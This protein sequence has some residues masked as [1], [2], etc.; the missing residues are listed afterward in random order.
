MLRRAKSFLVRPQKPD[1][2]E[3][4]YLPESEHLRRQNMPQ[5]NRIN[6]TAIPEETQPQIRRTSVETRSFRRK[7]SMS[8][9]NVMKIGFRNNNSRSERQMEFPEKSLKRNISIRRGYGKNEEITSGLRK[10]EDKPI[11]EVQQNNSSRLRMNHTVNK[12]LNENK[13]NSNNTNIK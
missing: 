1:D 13:Q 7:I 5:F 4:P 11:Y 12:K 8:L 9:D 2:P 6:T 3:D 10:I